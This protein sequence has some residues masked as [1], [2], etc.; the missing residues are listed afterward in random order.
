MNQQQPSDLEKKLKLKFKQTRLLKQ[1]LIHRSYLN[2][3]RGDQ[4]QSNERLEF[5]GDAILSFCISEKL[6][7]Q[8]P[9]YPEGD[10]TNIRS[11]LVKTTSLAAIASQLKLG[12]YLNL[13]HGE[14]DSGGRTNTSILADSLEALIGAIFLDTGLESVHRFIN[15]YF[16][17]KLAELIQSGSFKDSKSLLQ[18]KVQANNNNPPPTYQTLK[19]EGPD[20]QKTFTVGVFLNQK[21]LATAKGKNKREAE[22][23]AAGKA[24]TKKR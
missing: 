4:L 10:L 6:Y 21:L 20:H 11:N 8:F 12:S 18:E 15:T 3:S 13:S 5:L 2:E 22:E 7:R 17:P 1:S 23:A 16:D 19:E 14:D 9:N 24:L